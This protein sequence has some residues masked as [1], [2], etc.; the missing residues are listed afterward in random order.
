MRRSLQSFRAATAK[1]VS[2][3]VQEAFRAA[4]REASAADSA[5]QEYV[6]SLV[7]EIELMRV[8]ASLGTS[9]AVFN[10]EV[11]SVL[12]GASA[13]YASL[14]D[15]LA[16]RRIPAA[17]RAKL[18]FAGDSLERLGDLATYINAYVS[19]SQRREREPQ[20]LYA[21]LE[22]FVN[23]LSGT[24]ARG[25]TI[26]WNVKPRALRTEPMTRSELETVLINFLTNSIKAM[27][28]EGLHERRI[29]SFCGRSRRSGGAEVPR[30]RYRHRP[31]H[32][33]DIFEPFVS[34][35][36]SSVTALGIGTGL[37]L[38]IVS[39]IA[40]AYDGTV[41]IGRPDEGYT[42]CFEFS[43][44]RW[45]HQVKAD[46]PA[47]ADVRAVL[48]D[49]QDN[50]RK[51]Y[52]DLLSGERLT[53]VPVVPRDQIETVDDIEA[54]CSPDTPSVVILDYRLDESPSVGTEA[55]ASPPPSA[56]ASRISR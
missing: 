47:H 6:A 8:L 50:D 2:S 45:K 23:Q 34:D 11:Q 29:Q 44:P 25:V 24:L 4:G 18:D 31:V 26:D 39:D 1:R 33:G 9:I 3:L 43:V 27:N 42:T 46:N 22:A 20:P 48:V 14:S 52:A 49:D 38:K 54:I 41:E 37:G 53:V 35:T 17:T 12:N 28:K 10:H 40:E 13:A 16:A 36:R 55:E 5:E 15:D 19:V 7:G 56:T 21:V 32:R 51:Q 30:Y